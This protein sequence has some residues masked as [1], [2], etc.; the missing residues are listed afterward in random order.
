MYFN[1]RKDQKRV[2]SCREKSLS[3]LKLHVQSVASTE[4]RWTIQRVTAGWRGSRQPLSVSLSPCLGRLLSVLCDRFNLTA[5][6]PSAVVYVCVYVCVSVR[7]N[8]C[9]WLVTF[10][11]PIS[12][13]M[14][15]W[16]MA[17]CM[18]KAWFGGRLGI[19]TLY[20]RPCLMLWRNNIL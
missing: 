12:S 4:W 19:V 5:P 6:L 1:R 3:V 7:A 11:R 2:V 16:C 13:C 8:S 14:G 20:F 10:T 9:M 15:A 17:C 18:S